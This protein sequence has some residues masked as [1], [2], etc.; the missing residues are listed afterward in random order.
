MSVNI[1][2]LK[3]IIKALIEETKNENLTS[4]N[5]KAEATHLSSLTDVQK[6]CIRM[7]GGIL[8]MEYDYLSSGPDKSN[9]LGPL[10]K[11]YNDLVKADDE[12]GLEDFEE[13]VQEG[14]SRGGVPLLTKK[15]YD[16]VM[17]SAS[18]K[19]PEE[20]IVYKSGDDGMPK[21][22]RWI[23]TCT[24]KGQYSDY[25]KETKYVLPKGTPVIFTHGLADRDEVI[26]NT[27]Y[28]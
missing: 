17:N 25:G 16:T 27:K 8:Y 20:L 2:Q 26:I 3:T 14:A 28:L 10:V 11:E 9:R 1:A 19:I 7:W 5:E 4:L 18:V 24:I 22:D 13:W 15:T 12:E 23:S 6:F 21:N